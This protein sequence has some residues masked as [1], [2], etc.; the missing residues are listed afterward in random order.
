MAFLTKQ[1]IINPTEYMGRSN[2]SKINNEAILNN[3]EPIS[4]TCS[5]IQQSTPLSTISKIKKEN[6]IDY[7]VTEL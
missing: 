1:L 7:F 4:Q 6:N 3:S 5:R 2:T